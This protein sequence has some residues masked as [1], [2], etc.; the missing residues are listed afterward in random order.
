MAIKIY[1]YNLSQSLFLWNK[2]VNAVAKKNKVIAFLQECPKCNKTSVR[3]CP[4]FKVFKTIGNAGDLVM[5]ISNDLYQYRKN[6]Q[7]LSSDKYYQRIIFDG[8]D[9]INVHMKSGVCEGNTD[10]H[11][12]YLEQ[13]RNIKAN[14]RGKSIIGGDFNVN[15]FGREMTSTKG[16]FAKRTFHEISGKKCEDGFINLFWN[17][18]KR[19]P[20][21]LPVGT[22]EASYDAPMGMAIFDQFIFHKDLHLSVKAFGILNHFMGGLVKNIHAQAVQHKTKFGKAKKDCHLPVYLSIDI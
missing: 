6:I 8:I 20:S 13:V 10:N 9:L 12:K 7:I 16:W 19:K 15:P 22:I 4:G 2:F 17:P 11:D 3:R 21:M 14:I 1:S 5:L 18:I